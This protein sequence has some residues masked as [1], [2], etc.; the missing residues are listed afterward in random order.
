MGPTRICLDPINDYVLERYSKKAPHPLFPVHTVVPQHRRVKAEQLG[1]PLESS[2]L[3]HHVNEDKTDNDPENLELTDRSAH[4]NHHRL[5]VSATTRQKMSAADRARNACPE[6]KK[7]LRERALRQ[8]SQGNIG[9]PSQR[10]GQ[11]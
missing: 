1:R 4:M 11:Q 10:K 7:L 2:E 8:W 9:K 5:P 3:V 6:H